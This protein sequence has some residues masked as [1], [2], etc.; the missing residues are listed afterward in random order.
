M[1]DPKTLES[2]INN[3]WVKTSSSTKKA[4]VV[5]DAG[6]ATEDNLE[7]IRNKGYDYMCVSR[8]THSVS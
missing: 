6:I 2:M 3:L 1:S 7:M 4:L 5:I 8:S